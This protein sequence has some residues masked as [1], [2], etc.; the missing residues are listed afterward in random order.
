MYSDVEPRALE[1]LKI[2]LFPNE[3]KN[4]D[5][6]FIPEQE[7]A[8]IDFDFSPNRPSVFR[9]S[10]VKK[11]GSAS[12]FNKPDP[13]GERSHRKHTTKHKVV[14]FESLLLKPGKICNK[15]LVFFDEDSN[16]F[17]RSN[18]QEG[19]DYF[20]VDGKTWK[21]LEKWYGFDVEAPFIQESDNDDDYS[22]DDEQGDES[23]SDNGG[24]YS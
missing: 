24:D 23:S 6:S 8:E 17:L 10:V 11:S 9:P 3:K 21:F 7:G 13:N 2:K 19:K 20:L 5:P 15:S 12:S 14:S 22:E 18:I 4:N 1:D 16:I